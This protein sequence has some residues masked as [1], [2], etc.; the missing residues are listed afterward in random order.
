MENTEIQKIRLDALPE[1]LSPAEIAKITTVNPATARI[2]VREG[3]IPGAKP[4]G[5]RV[6]KVS[7][8]HVFAFLKEHY[9]ALIIEDP[10][11]A[12]KAA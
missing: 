2:W 3:V 1:Y 8:A 6:K 11:P 5:R 12:S 9:P 7:R 4:F 10:T